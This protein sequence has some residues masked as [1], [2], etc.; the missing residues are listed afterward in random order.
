MLSD[1]FDRKKLLNMMPRQ[2]TSKVLKQLNIAVAIRQFL[3]KLMS[4]I[5]TKP[6]TVL[7]QRGSLE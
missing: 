4:I 1:K 7:F 3:L 6:S 2:A 5:S